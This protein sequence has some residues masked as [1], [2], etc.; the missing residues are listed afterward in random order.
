M[1][2]AHFRAKV[3]PR[4][5]YMPQGLGK[6]LYPTLSVFENVFLPGCSGMTVP[7]ASGASQRCLPATTGLARFADRPGRQAQ[8]A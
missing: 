8:A 1:A 3:C 2:S 4:I 6:N 7:S 5:A